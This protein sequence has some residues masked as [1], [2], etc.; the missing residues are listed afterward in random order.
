[1]ANTYELIASS[2]VGSGGSSAVEF[3]DLKT[4]TDIVF[5]M[6]VRTNRSSTSDQLKITFNSN[7]ANY[8]GR[9]L[10]SNG[11]SVYSETNT[12]AT[13]GSTYLIGEY[14]TAANN[15]ANTFGSG[16]L[17]IPNYGSSNY[18][19]VSMELAH[20]NNASLGYL[21]MTAGLWSNTSAMTSVKF[22]SANGASFVQYSTFYLYGIKNS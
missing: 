11:T 7:T 4:Y 22:E 5:K 12:A 9:I 14:I 15:T 2:T 18:K 8:S 17:Y 13:G 20:E 21:S 10:Y 6:S 3:T 16:E 1:M 19:S